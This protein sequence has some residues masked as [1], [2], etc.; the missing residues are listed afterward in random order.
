M[1]L[2]R[3]TFGR[4]SASARDIVERA[5]QQ[6]LQDDADVVVA[7]PRAAR[8]RAA[9]CR[10]SS[11]SPP[12]RCARSCRAPRRPRRR[13]AGSRGRVV[14]EV[15]PSAVSLTLTLESSPRARSR[16]DASYA[17]DERARLVLVRD[18]L[19][20][21]VD[22]G[23]LPSALSSDTSRARPRARARRCSGGEFR[24]SGLGTAGSTGRSR[25]RRSPR[26]DGRSISARA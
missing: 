1:P 14:V 8:G 12:C 19:A 24:T 20:E 22:R 6:G 16:E 7:L 25:D 5:P 11:T 15:S 3:R 2:H 26:G 13:R 9:A 23:H 17:R 10:R 4:R 18:V 21:D